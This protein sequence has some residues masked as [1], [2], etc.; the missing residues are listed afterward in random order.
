MAGPSYSQV[1][2]AGGLGTVT[3]DSPMEAFDRAVL[4]A[5]NRTKGYEDIN[6]NRLQQIKSGQLIEENELKLKRM[7]DVEAWRQGGMIGPPPNQ[8]TYIN[9]FNQANPMTRGFDQSAVQSGA[10]YL[11][12]NYQKEAFGVPQSDSSVAQPTEIQPVTKPDATTPVR[13]KSSVVNE[14]TQIW[15][16]LE[17]RFNLPDGYLAR[18]AEIESDSNPNAQNP[19]STAGGLFQFVDGTA[20]E[21]GLT[22]KFDPLESSIAA[23]KL[24]ANNQIRLEQLIG[25]RPTSAELYLAHQQGADGAAKLINMAE[26]QPTDL[27]TS[28]VG[29][30]EVTLNGGNKQTTVSEF[31]KLWKNKFVG[32]TIQNM[33]KQYESL[34]GSESFLRPQEGI[35]AFMPEDRFANSGNEVFGPALRRYTM[36]SPQ[37]YDNAFT[38]YPEDYKQEVAATE[39]TGVLGDVIQTPAG[40]RPK[41]N[42]DFPS[43]R[44]PENPAGAVV[45]QDIVDAANATNIR[46]GQR[47]ASAREFPEGPAGDGFVSVILNAGTTGMAEFDYN[48]RTG[49]VR[50]RSTTAEFMFSGSETAKANIKQQLANQYSLDAEVTD[51][52]NAERNVNSLTEEIK[53]ADN[54]KRTVIFNNFEILVGRLR[55]E[56][57]NAS[58]EEYAEKLERYTSALNELEAAK[59]QLN[60]ATLNIPGQFRVDRN[61]FSGEGPEAGITKEA[62][63]K[64][65]EKLKKLETARQDIKQK[66]DAVFEKAAATGLPQNQITNEAG[67]KAIEKS[68]QILKQNGLKVTGQNANQ[69]VVPV[70]AKMYTLDPNKVLLA[71]KQAA[72]A[73]EH[74]ALL[75]MQGKATEYRTLQLSL[76]QTESYLMG[77]EVIQEVRKGNLQVLANLFATTYQT[78]DVDLRV[79]SDNKISIS[80]KGDPIPAIQNLTTDQV[81]EYLGFTFDTQYKDAQIALSTSA[82]EFQQKLLTETHKASLDLQKELAKANSTA[83]QNTIIERFKASNKVTNLD[84]QAGTFTYTDDYGRLYYVDTQSPNLVDPDSKTQPYV[85]R[86]QVFEKGKL[87]DIEQVQ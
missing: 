62:E 11:E 73:T 32:Q 10:N 55:D 50:P 56:V 60:I 8:K 29:I 28:L 9:D 23:A 84:S 35:T 25:R 54:S 64:N 21:Y 12:S 20:A 82:V 72:L 5:Q 41:I 51:Y 39:K 71:R 85:V 48:P 22:N 31:V 79:S 19:N 45:P 70:N 52:K 75:R 36:E 69:A 47:A 7:R 15:K 66:A 76:T 26:T 83:A 65:L 80:V 59:T 1:R 53:G 3:G 27:A 14:F 81:V 68:V 38:A 40:I 33:S 61:V 49:E 43:P 77:M 4:G 6:T 37:A 78:S 74:L 86:V 63:Q 2:Q 67:Q 42:F 58:P 24:A 44:Q 87:V 16:N 18:T 57:D 46:A 30:D 13:D 34:G 17:G